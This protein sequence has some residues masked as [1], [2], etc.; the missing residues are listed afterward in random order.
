MDSN[1]QT[2]GGESRNGQSGRVKNEGDREKHRSKRKK[3]RRDRDRDRDRRRE[4]TRKS[5]R[6]RRRST[7]YSKSKSR[8]RSR[9]RSRR[10]KKRRTNSNK[11]SESD[12]S[13][14]R[15]VYVAGIHPEMKDSLIKEFFEKTVSQ[16]PDR[17]QCPGSIVSNI[18]V[19]H[20]QMFS[21]MEFT[22]S[23]DAEIAVC[24]DGAKFMGYPLQIRGA[25]ESEMALMGN[26]QQN[27]NGNDT[28]ANQVP[29]E[30]VDR[31][32]LGGMPLKFSGDQIRVLISQFGELKSF[33]LIRDSIS[34]KSKG[35]A[36]FSF[37][38]PNDIQSALSA[39]N[40]RRVDGKILVCHLANQKNSNHQGE[41]N[42]SNTSSLKSTPQVRNSD[43]QHPNTQQ[44]NNTRSTKNGLGGFPQKG[45]RGQSRILKLLNMVSREDLLNDEEYQDILLDIREECRL[46]GK[47]I[48]IFV[49]R[50]VPSGRS[51]GVPSHPDIGAIFVEYLNLKGALSARD[52]IKGRKFNDREIIIQ[53]MPEHIWNRMVKS[54]PA[55]PS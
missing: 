7:S 53:F 32:F 40:G 28:I 8:S 15:A 45:S 16:V 1:G 35:C 25:T 39:L 6:R 10:S 20:E 17:P 22:T 24:M 48:R 26:L 29:N 3:D 52:Y 50:P 47:L 34:N 23:F 18:I 19:N 38:D 4:K 37:K 44:I 30:P 36:Y 27:N 46:F 54:E 49:P 55:L 31:I 42:A 21:L 14:A 43:A 51:W 5:S 13:L 11:E 33:T 12:P 41:N 9:G 2:N